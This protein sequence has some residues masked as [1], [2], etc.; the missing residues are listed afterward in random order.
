MQQGSFGDEF[1][2]FKFDDTSNF[3]GCVGG[4]LGLQNEVQGIVVGMYGFVFVSEY[5]CHR[6]RFP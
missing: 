5:T 4:E 3:V 2:G 6:R 1:R